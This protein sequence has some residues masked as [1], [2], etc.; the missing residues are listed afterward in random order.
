M[1]RWRRGFKG[2]SEHQDERFEPQFDCKVDELLETAWIL[3]EEG[4]DSFEDLKVRADH[5]FD[6]QFENASRSG[7]IEVKNGKFTLLPKGHERAREIIRRHRLTEVLLTELFDM[8]ESHAESDACRFEHIL[9]PEVT[10]SVC[11]LLG[12]PPTCPHGKPIP[13][14]ECCEKF[15]KEMTPLVTPLMELRPGDTGRIVF[16]TPKSHTILDR[17]TSLGIVPGSEVRL[18]QKRPTCIVKI[19]ET[20]IAID[21]NIARE[22]FVKR[23]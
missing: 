7:I 15:K 5:D 10:E 17:L 13:R 11:T 12:H 16:I 2:G 20:D 6:V 23:V 18:H 4:S 14:G 8:E 19:G 3:E 9:S 1:R 22:I 21:S